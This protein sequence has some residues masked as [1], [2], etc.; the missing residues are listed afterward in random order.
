MELT[1]QV[2]GNRTQG[3]VEKSW[4]EA[5][6][7]KLQVFM[8]G[9]FNG[10]ERM[11][12][13]PEDISH[14]ELELLCFMIHRQLL[15]D[16]ELVQDGNPDEQLIAFKKKCQEKGYEMIIDVGEGK[17][18][19]D[20]SDLFAL[21][22]NRILRVNVRFQ[23]KGKSLKLRVINNRDIPPLVAHDPRI[24]LEGCLETFCKKE[25][26]DSQNMWYCSDCKTHRCGIQEA[27]FSRAP[28]VLVI[29][30]KRFISKVKG[31]DDE[32]MQYFSKNQ[33]MV[34]YPFELDLSKLLFGSSEK[35]E[36]SL[37]GVVHHYGGLNG[38]HY[39]ASCRG[40]DDEWYWFDDESVQRVEKRSVVADTAYVLFNRKKINLN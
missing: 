19:T 5:F 30:L 25:C 6:K 22:H 39:E 10:I 4:E 15:I 26:L 12:E 11:V 31:I 36:Y 3:V 21:S 18:I 37:L 20:S 29:H 38:G 7:L 13:V 23:F 14:S 2:F 24:T 27:R 28:Q 16:E 1:R 35:T 33:K 17:T 8:N 32:R 40:E 34:H 9:Q